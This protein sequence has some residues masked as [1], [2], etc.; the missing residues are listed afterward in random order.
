[1]LLMDRLSNIYHERQE[2]DSS[3]C[4]Q[5]CLNALLQDNIFSAADLAELGRQLDER[6]TEAREGVPAHDEADT[7]SSGGGSRRRQASPPNTGRAGRAYLN[8]SRSS[9]VREKLSHTTAAQLIQQHRWMTLDSSA[10]KL[11]TRLLDPSI[12]SS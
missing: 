8:A 10:P 12:C 4:A 6:E 7:W 5:H 2:P 11:W 9:N 1:M 3:L